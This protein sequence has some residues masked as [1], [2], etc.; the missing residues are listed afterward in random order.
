MNGY[1]EEDAEY[2][3]DGCGWVLAA[4][5]I[6]A[7]L[8]FR[9]CSKPAV[10]AKMPD[11]KTETYTVRNFDIGVVNWGRTTVIR[12]GN[13]RLEVATENV[14]VIHDRKGEKKNE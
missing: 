4:I 8:V 1:T 10:D 11:G 5:I 6:V 12:L 13:K 2:L 9:S 7:L 14:T 3:A